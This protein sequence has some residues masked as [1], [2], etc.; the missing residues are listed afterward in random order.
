MRHAVGGH[1]HVSLER[2][3]W[4]VVIVVSVVARSQQ[5]CEEKKWQRADGMMEYA[6]HE[7]VFQNGKV[8]FT[9]TR[10]RAPSM[11]MIN[12]ASK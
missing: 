5:K 1:A 7:E 11:V 12:V 2:R 3:P 10:E 4:I 6:K 8:E 9:T